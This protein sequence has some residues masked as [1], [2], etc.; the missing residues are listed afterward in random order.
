[1]T[2]QLGQIVEGV[3][4]IQFAGVDQAQ[5][6]VPRRRTV[7]GL[8]E[9]GILAVQDRLFQGPLAEIIVQR[10]AGHAQEQ[11]QLLPMLAQV[12]DR[13]PQARVGFDQLLFDLPFQPAPQLLH[14][15]TALLLVKAQ[16]LLGRQTIFARNW[17]LR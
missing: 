11:R 9:Q 12:A 3:G 17:S 13:R 1:M 10:R 8:E 4:P 14:R 15:R 7:A 2:L 16:P 5:I 6:Q